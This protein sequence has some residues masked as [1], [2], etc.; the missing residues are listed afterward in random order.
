[1]Q[2]L[3]VPAEWAGSPLDEFLAAHWPRA[4]KGKLRDLVRA[5]VVTVDGMRAQPSDRLRE[6]QVVLLDRDPTELE[7]TDVHAVPLEVLYEDEHLVAVDKP[8]G[9]PVEP[10][11]WG[12]H[13]VHLSGAL[14]RWA[15][16]RQGEGPMRRRPRGLHRLDL[17]T[18]GVLLYALSLEAERFYRDLFATGGVA[19]TYHALVLGR[20]DGPCVVD[21]PIAA[22][23]RGG[24]RMRVHRSGK[25]AR[26]AFTPVEE[27]R[28]HTWVEARPET[29]RTHQIRVHLAH[30]G[31]PLAVDPR[32]GGGPALY[33]SHF[34][35][36]YR[37]KPGKE[38]KPLVSRLTL[39][40][41]EVVLP[42][43]PD[44]GELRISAPL[45]KDLR[46]ALAKLRKWAPVRPA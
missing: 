28:G 13:P 11:R 32:Y 30:L 29:G 23:T 35:R 24:G 31:H 22:D 34:K 44:G 21:E 17:G 37:P 1:M 7:R 40:A 39:H 36:G 4:P 10:S 25:P 19:K 42:R 9:L 15:E 20:M 8:A 5:G 27:F 46:V 14:L 41:S 33:L 26:T 2:T 38:E 43:Y 16:E 12:E 18:S 6:G 3:L 45:P